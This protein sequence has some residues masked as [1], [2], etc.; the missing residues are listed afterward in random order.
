MKKILLNFIFLL[1]TTVNV[2]SAEY[3]WFQIGKYNGWVETNSTSDKTIRILPFIVPPGSLYWS[4]AQDPVFYSVDSG[5]KPRPTGITLTADN[6]IKFGYKLVSDNRYIDKNLPKNIERELN[7]PNGSLAN[8]KIV[9]IKVRNV[10]VKMEVSGEVVNIHNYDS[11]FTNGDLT[12][13]FYFDLSD[14]KSL[15][16]IRSKDFRLIANYDFPFNTFSSIEIQLDKTILSNSWVQVFR[17]IVKKV[18]KTG[19]SFLGF[20]WGREVQRVYTEE[21]IDKG[22]SNSIKEKI[23][24]VMKDPTSGQQER[25]N[26]LLGMIKSSS[27][28]ATK[29]HTNA[30][31]AAIASGNLDLAKAHELYLDNIKAEINESE[32]SD[33]LLAKLEK[34]TEDQVTTFLLS[35]LKMGS[36]SGSS[37]YRYQGSSSLSVNTTLKTEYK[38]YVIKSSEVSYS[39]IN[40]PSVRPEQYNLNFLIQQ[41]RES[42]NL[43]LFG[44]KWENEIYH[45]R[46]KA[47]F[48]K[49][50]KNNDIENIKYCINLNTDV[51]GAYFANKDV[52]ITID[53][54]KNT[55]LHY[56]SKIGNLEVVELLLKSGVNPRI[57]NR[58]SETALDFAEENGN[59]SIITKLKEVSDYVGIAEVTINHPTAS[60]KALYLDSPSSIEKNTYKI[61]NSNEFKWFFK[62]YP[63]SFK[64][65]GRIILNQRITVN[66]YY[67]FNTPRPQVIQQTG[68]EVIIEY[69]IFF[70][71]NFK[72]RNNERTPYE[73]SIIWKNGA[74]IFE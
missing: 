51:G 74:Y 69:T 63:T 3:E 32:M 24:V 54:D 19:G 21:Q 50:L 37:Y 13:G 35:G 53:N 8:H 14:Y 10:S 60:I 47:G 46:W 49:S 23:Q 48:I 42:I 15:S 31:N 38:E 17:K 39:S 57:L 43:S 33:E 58:H 12:N 65:T 62:S 30:K 2:F 61:V 66:D 28:E 67:K 26:Q 59:N 20:S 4:N 44:V 56:A 41:A 1:L 18:R 70:K 16:A 73:H 52:N 7:L 45:N 25:F 22:S 55:A 5:T 71:G 27:D 72:I 40:D 68:N 11:K 64:P 9:F 36:S 6:R 29:L 34:L